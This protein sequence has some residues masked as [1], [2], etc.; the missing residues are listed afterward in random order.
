M[1][2]HAEQEEQYI[3]MVKIKAQPLVAHGFS[4]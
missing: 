1:G 3:S 4:T 2:A